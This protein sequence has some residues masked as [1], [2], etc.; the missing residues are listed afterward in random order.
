ME[1]RENDGISRRDFL[2]SAGLAGGAAAAGPGAL[3]GA[4]AAPEAPQSKESPLLS[5]FQPKSMLHAKETRVPR[6]RFPV[7]DVHN[8]VNDARTSEREQIPPAKILEIMDRSNIRQIVILTGAWGKRLQKVVD[9]MVNPYPD[10]FRVFTQIDWSRID[11]PDF[12]RKMVEQIDDAVARGARGLKILKNLGLGVRDKTG[13]LV[14]VDDPR[15]D[16]V[17]EECGR[18]GIPV[19]IHVSDPEAF[20]LPVD[21]FNER[22]EELIH[23]PNWSF[24]G[25][26]YPSK[27]AILDARDRMF[28][29]HPGTTF[30][31]LHVATWPENLDYVSALLNRLP[32]VMVEFG[33]REAELGRQPRNSRK[34]FDKYQDRIMFGTDAVPPPYGNVTPQQIFGDKLYQI[35]CRFLETEDEYFDYA[36]APTPPQ[37]RW[38]IYGVGLP[39]SILRKVYYENAARLLKVKI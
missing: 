6:A 34:F 23:N 16:P 32:N 35:Y 25:D 31:A 17:W 9:R 19:S 37:G 3:I 13:E 36:P 28:A 20:F 2:I 39:D 12:S 4:S 15:L 29:R 26:E 8:H 7:I 10:R 22:Y 33:A 18:L 14:A 5:E 38:Q 27:Q 21:R 11:D 1:N 24:Y 30:I